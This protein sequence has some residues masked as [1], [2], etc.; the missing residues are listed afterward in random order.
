MIICD[1][2]PLASRGQILERIKGVDA[3]Y[4]ATKV[5]LDEEMLNAAGT[6]LAPIVLLWFACFGFRTTVENRC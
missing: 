2:K 1:E 3:A 5:H 4:W 6:V